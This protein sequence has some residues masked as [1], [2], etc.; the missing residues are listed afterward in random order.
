MKTQR[1]IDW[2]L[3]G[4]DEASMEK[5]SNMILK[6]T[7]DFVTAF[8]A[9]LLLSPVFVVIALMIKI[10]TPGPVFF[11]QKRVGQHAGIFTLHKFRTM[12]V[13]HKGST[14]TVKGEHR[15]T[16]LGAF[17][18]KYK[19]DE[20]PGFWNIL[21]GEMSLV[22]PRPDVPGYADMLNPQDRVIL[23]LKPGLTGPAT[24]KY[25]NEEEILARQA[26]PAEYNDRVI[27][28]DKVRINKHYIENWSFLLDLK[29]IIYTVLGKKLKD[30]WAQ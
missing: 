18:R 4:Y 5:H 28:P 11:S 8:M 13:N 10:I 7:F 15:I 26:Y 27:Y 24:M 17:L 22:G 12:R 19:L 30:K 14:I 1:L 9:L 3:I 21:R 29:I 25:S 23:D 6:R 20:L 2:V 16:P